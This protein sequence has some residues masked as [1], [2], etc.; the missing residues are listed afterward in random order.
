[1]QRDFRSALVIW[2]TILLSISDFSF[3][4]EEVEETPISAF[5]LSL[6]SVSRKKP[7][8]TPSCKYMKNDNCSENIT[9]KGTIIPNAA[10]KQGTYL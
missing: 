6:V 9:C 7:K 3:K 10:A 2:S 1:M 4:A 5:A 8:S